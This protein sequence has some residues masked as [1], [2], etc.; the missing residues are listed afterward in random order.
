[1]HFP[2][3]HRSIHMIVAFTL[4]LL[5]SFGANA[6]SAVFSRGGAALRGYDPVAYFTLGKPVR[7]SRDFVHVWRGAEWRFTSAEHLERFRAD[8]EAWAP[9]YGGWCAYAM[10]QGHY[11]RT[12]PEAWTIVEGRLYLNYSQSVKQTWLKD[13]DAY[14]E[15]ADAN[16]RRLQPE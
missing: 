11:A 3:S 1:M 15:A 14:I 13:R 5:A 12:D 10:S 7:G 4:L 8:P 9:Q 6:E 2:I 16:W